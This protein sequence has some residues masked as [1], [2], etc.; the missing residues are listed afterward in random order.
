[1]KLILKLLGVF[2]FC[3]VAGYAFYRFFYKFM[4]P[5][6]KIQVDETVNGTPF[7]SWNLTEPMDPFDF[8]KSS[9]GFSDTVTAGVTI[10]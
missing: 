4:N 5:T 9:K 8:T 6:F 2:C 1:M 7:T 10:P 3:V